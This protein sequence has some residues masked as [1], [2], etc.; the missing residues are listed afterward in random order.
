MNRINRLGARHAPQV[1]LGR[2]MGSGAARKSP[3]EAGKSQGYAGGIQ[4][5]VRPRLA[6]PPVR[7]KFGNE[8]L[9]RPRDHL[10]ARGS[11][12]TEPRN[13]PLDAP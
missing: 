12:P 10:P 13:G 5:A 11:G 3:H 9:T 2:H 8:A 1:A 4:T 7:R 6:E